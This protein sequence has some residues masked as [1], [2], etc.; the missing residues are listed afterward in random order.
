MVDRGHDREKWI[1]LPAN[2]KHAWDAA[3][4]AEL[5]HALGGLQREA[6]QRLF[7]AIYGP[8]LSIAYPTAP[9]PM[10]ALITDA[11]IVARAVMA[12]I[13]EPEPERRPFGEV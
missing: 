12:M 6:A 10:D 13:E 4:R 5:D 7:E 11:G 3:S 2:I 8:G 9:K 1:E